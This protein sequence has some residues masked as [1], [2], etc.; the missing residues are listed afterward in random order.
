[1]SLRERLEQDTTQAEA[2]VPEQSGEM[3]IGKIVAIGRRVTEYSP[4][5]YLILTVQ[6]EQ[7]KFRAVHAFHYV[8]Q[9]ELRKY[10][11]KPG[12]E[13]G[14]KFLGKPEGKN[15]VSYRVEADA[16]ILQPGEADPAY[17]PDSDIPSDAPTH[18]PAA[19][20]ADDDIP[21]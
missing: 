3:L 11:L 4:E 10:K 8:L 14:I 21:F 1:M 12:I 19:S 9:E 6:D 17:T 15:Y 20:A 16:E 2:W 18:S 13:I 5:G 7:G